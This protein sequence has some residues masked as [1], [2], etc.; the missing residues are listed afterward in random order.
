MNKPHKMCTTKFKLHT[1]FDGSAKSAAEALLES[2]KASG[3]EAKMMCT[4]A[5]VP[6]TFN[7]TAKSYEVMV[8]Q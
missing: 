8:E 4:M 3:K 7:F 1:A 2:I 5:R 6:R